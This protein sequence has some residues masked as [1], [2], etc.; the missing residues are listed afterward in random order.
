M[1]TS[2]PLVVETTYKYNTD[3]IL[4]SSSLDIFI[5]KF[6]LVLIIL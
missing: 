2:N 1:H 4:L 3:I 5:L 6:L